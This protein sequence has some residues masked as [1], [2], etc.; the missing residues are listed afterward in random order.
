MKNHLS[1]KYMEKKITDVDFNEH[2][3][4][5]ILENKTKLKIWDDGQNC[6]EKRYMTCDDNIEDLIGRKLTKILIK[7]IEDSDDKENVTAQFFVNNVYA[8]GGEE[9]WEHEIAF[10][11]ICTDKNSIILQAHNVHNGYHVCAPYTGSFLL[12]IKE[13][14]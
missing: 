8:W 6:C 14:K 5:I 12:E 3:L 9:E 10:V 2:R 4:V 7:K 11:E 1:K 13:E